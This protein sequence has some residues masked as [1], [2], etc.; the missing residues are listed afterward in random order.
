MH[1][2]PR[3]GDLPRRGTHLAAVGLRQQGA[4]RVHHLRAARQRREEP[5]G[6][7]RERGV[8]GEHAR[9][10]RDQLVRRG[11]E[12]ARGGQPGLRVELPRAHHG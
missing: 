12:P 7:D 5:V 9:T 4:E 1:Q 2:R 8:I 3:L 6:A 11:D 10:G